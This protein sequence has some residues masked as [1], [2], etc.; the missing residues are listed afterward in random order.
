MMGVGQN[1]TKVLLIHFPMVVIFI[2]I[3]DYILNA[4]LIDFL[5][6]FLLLTQNINKNEII[7]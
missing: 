4:P 6:Q 3:F 1:I 2:Q 7:I 5:S